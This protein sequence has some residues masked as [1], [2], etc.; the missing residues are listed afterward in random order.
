MKAIIRLKQLF[1]QGKKLMEDGIGK[2]K[3][4][5]WKNAN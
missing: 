4:Y 1:G 5:L 3:I 2:V